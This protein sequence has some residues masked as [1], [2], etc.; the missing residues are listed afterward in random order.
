VP[1]GRNA[2]FVGHLGA[3]EQLLER[4]PPDANEDDCQRTAIEGLGGV[5]KTQLAL[6]AAYQIHKKY[7]ECLVFWMPAIDP[8]NFDNAYRD[9]GQHLDLRGLQSGAIYLCTSLSEHPHT[10]IND[11]LRRRISQRKHTQ[12]SPNYIYILI[13]RRPAGLGTS[14]GLF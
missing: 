1:F 13:R 8:T 3:L 2:E 6:E 4:I 14:M 7:P 12:L 9:I 10:I 11:S 5:G